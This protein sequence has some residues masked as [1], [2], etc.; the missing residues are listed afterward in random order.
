MTTR[1]NKNKKLIENNGELTKK[2]I[3]ELNDNFLYKKNN[4]SN[5]LFENSYYYIS[6]S[7]NFLYKTIKI[8]IKISGVFLLWIFLHFFA[9]YLYTKLCVPTTLFGL[10]M[11]PFLTSTPHCQALRWI[12]YNGANFINNMWIVVGTWLC[13]N[14]MDL[15]K[16]AD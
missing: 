14:I 9:S 1:S 13:A 5:T 12:I 15:N 16:N 8:I 10:I 3:N 11:S 4:I 2:E 7:F 6:F